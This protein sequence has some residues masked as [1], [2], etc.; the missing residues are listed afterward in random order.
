MI[1][2][3]KKR[4]IKKRANKGVYLTFDDGPHEI[5]TPRILDILDKFDVK[6]TFFIVGKN[7]ERYPG[8]V[9]HIYNKGHDIG[10]H[11]YS[12]PGSPLLKIKK[13]AFIEKEIIKTDK[14]IEDITGKRPVLFRPPLAFWDVSS[15]ILKRRAKE[16]GYL[17]VGWSFSTMDW[18]G[19]QC[20]IKKKYLRQP[21]ND[22]D[23]VLLHDGS[24]NALVKRR[25]ATVKILPE[26]IK[27]CI[28]NSLQPLP[29]SSLLSSEYSNR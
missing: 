27:D 7:A 3:N 12:H 5:Y 8:I 25:W 6:A 20:I 4:I 29:L 22:G 17:C 19:S 11:T 26:I 16:Y 28:K 1:I 2:N 14:I 9:K 18:L 15:E 10:N 13:K 23:I 24:E 21:K